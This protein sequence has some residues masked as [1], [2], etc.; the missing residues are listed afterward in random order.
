MILYLY[1]HGRLAC[2]IRNRKLITLK[3][4]EIWS[5]FA[6]CAS[7]CFVLAIAVVKAP[8][9]YDLSAT[10]RGTLDGAVFVAAF[11]SVMHL[12]IWIVIWLALTA[13][14]RW[15]FKLP[16]LEAPADQMQP[17][18]SESGAAYRPD[19]SRTGSEESGTETIYWPKTN[20]N[21]PKLRVTFNEVPNEDS[22]HGGK[23]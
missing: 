13:K 10:Y 2:V 7:F 18:L 15:H 5:Y 8:L 11:G 3:G 22:P 20:P 23:R 16:Q 4:G 9:I 12:F 1:G 17:L 19:L 21:S 6:H 14:R